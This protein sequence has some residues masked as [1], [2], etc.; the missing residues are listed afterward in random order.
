MRT[1]ASIDIGTDKIVAL[2]GE[3]DSYGDIHIIG[4]GEAKSKCINRGTVTRLEVAAR[5]ISTAVRE[6]EEMSGHKVTTVVINVSGNDLKSQNEKDTINISPSPT[7]IE[8]D[9]INRLL[10]RSIAKGKED[11]FEII[12]AIPRKYTLDDQEGIEDPTGLIGSKLTAQV[13]IVKAGTTLIGNLEKAVL[14]AGFT[15]TARIASALASAKAVLTEEEKESGVLLLDI[16]AG[17]TDYVLFLEGYPVVTG[18]VNMAGQNIT[19]D[20][21]F[22]MKVEQ[23]EAERTKKEDGLALVDL[24]REGEILKIRPRGEMREVAVEKRQLAEVIQIR[25]E[26]ILEKVMNGLESAGFKADSANAGVVVTGGTA[27]LKGIKDLVERFTDLPARIGYP[28]GIIGLK[29]RIEDPKYATAVGLLKFAVSPEGVLSE[30][31]TGVNLSTNS[32]GFKDIIEKIR[33]FFREIL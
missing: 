15:P 21:A 12:H 27:N 11:G 9:H 26:E 17:L 33:E 14:A 18:S 8:E 2:I 4:V 13:H 32:T 16:G 20:I 22:F 24:V 6:A 30:A 19:R 10:E 7:E 5:A 29:E 31:R 23:E 3:V 28:T 25:L 1:V